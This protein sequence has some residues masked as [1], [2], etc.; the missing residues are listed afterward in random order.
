MTERA[1][2]LL[3]A[4]NQGRV[5]VDLLRD[6]DVAVL[7]FLD[8]TK[9]EGARVDG[10][11]VLGP[12][13][14]A[15]ASD[16][17]ARARFLLAFG[18]PSERESW[19]EALRGSGATLF[20][21]VHPTARVAR[22]ATLGDGIFLSAYSV[23]FP[24]ATVGDFTMINNHCSIGHDCRIGAANLFGPGVHLSGNVTTGARCTFGAGSVVQPCR[25]LGRDVRVAG[26]ALVHESVG[27]RMTLV[28]NPARRVLEA[29]APGTP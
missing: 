9:S 21:L 11:P 29:G 7:G 4:G 22:T 10:V 17:H 8:D 1:V 25:T 6:A 14:K 13:A 5:A 18:S 28:G 27:D 15:L 26:G 3:G 24:N 16:W 19:G 2:I 12:F 20:S 23:V